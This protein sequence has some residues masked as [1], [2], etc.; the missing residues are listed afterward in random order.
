M[1][2]R[3]FVF[4]LI[5]M[6]LF[7]LG[8]LGQSEDR[9]RASEPRMDVRRT[10]AILSQVPFAQRKILFRTL[11]PTTKA[12]V[13]ITHLEDFLRLHSELDSNQRAIVK[14]AIALADGA[15]FESGA[16]QANAR[17]LAAQLD[18]AARLSFSAEM[19]EAAF[20]DLGPSN[21][22]TVIAFDP[23]ARAGTPMFTDTDPIVL[24]DCSC[25]HSFDYCGSGEC[26]LAGCKSVASGCGFIWAFDCNGHC[27]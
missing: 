10:Y 7:V 18:A 20:Y 15:L 1:R 27:Q 26:V 8:A 12:A 2:R 24:D 22:S 3:V 5:G 4:T 17:E 14:A 13:W 23:G 21:A 16:E 19:R 9:T 25:N 11:S 6:L